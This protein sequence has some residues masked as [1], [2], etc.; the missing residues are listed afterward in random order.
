MTLLKEIET[1]L[2]TNEIEEPF[3]AMQDVCLLKITLNSIE[4]LLRRQQPWGTKKRRRISAR[5]KSP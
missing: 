4:F 3:A 2:K 1:S 5:E